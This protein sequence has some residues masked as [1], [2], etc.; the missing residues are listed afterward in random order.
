MSSSHFYRFLSEI[1]LTEYG[2]GNILDND[3]DALRARIEFVQN[4]EYSSMYG[5]IMWAKLYWYLLVIFFIFLYSLHMSV[6]VDE[7]N[8]YH[9]FYYYYY[10]LLKIV[11]KIRYCERCLTM[12]RICQSKLTHWQY[13]SR[14]E[15]AT[16]EHCEEDKPLK[17][18]HILTE[19]TFLNNRKL[20]SFD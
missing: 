10:Y 2:V 13:M 17:I 6:F 14:E 8:Y 12:F 5:V 19:N 11:C 18:D 1:F 3:F 16:C 15:I 4:N 9:Y 20:Q 7:I